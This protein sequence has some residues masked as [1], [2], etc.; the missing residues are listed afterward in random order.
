[1]K[2]ELI[3]VQSTDKLEFPGLM[4]S[5]EK[6]TK[7]AAIWLHGMGDNATFYNPR[8]IN[9]LA[10][11]LTT[12]GI[13]LL[14]FNNRGAHNSKRLRI[15]DVTL[16]DDETGYQGG[17]HYEL[18]ADC[19]KDIDGAA[20]HLRRHGYNELYLIG[21]ST[22]ANKICAYHVRVKHSPFVKYV[23][24]GP[25]DDTGLFFSELGERKFQRA[26]NYAKEALKADQ[27]MKIM[28]RY[29]GMYPFSAQ[30]AA[31]ILD[32]DGAYN[33]F[34]FFETTTKRLGKKPLFSEYQQLNIPTLVI[35]GEHDEYANTAGDTRQALKLFK[36][37]IAK[38]PQADFQLVKDA[39]HS[40]HGK[41][42][43]FAKQVADWL[44]ENNG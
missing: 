15:V 20:D 9:A 30:A 16:P 2:L 23:L 18:I 10:E 26:L 12:R 1:M 44:G 31:D 7:R 41:E 6:P 29:T 36:K 21:H 39:D 3:T 43:A 28:P 5:P 40:F 11:A 25:G 27:G 22:G 33:T 42:K 14:A 38:I 35:F 8:R 34:P 13:S 4:Y 19:V 24:A 17:T 32:P 37:H